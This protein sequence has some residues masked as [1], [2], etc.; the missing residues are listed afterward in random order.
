MIPFDLFL[1]VG[2]EHL[3]QFHSLPRLLRY[4]NAL[5]IPCICHNHKLFRQHTTNNTTS[6]LLVLLLLH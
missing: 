4:Q 5:G 1:I 2:V 6:N 3:I